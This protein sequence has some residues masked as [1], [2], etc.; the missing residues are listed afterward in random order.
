MV[1][2][3]CGNQGSWNS[4]RSAIFTRMFVKSAN[5][6]L[7]NLPSSPVISLYDFI[8]FLHRLKL[9]AANLWMDFW[10][11]PTIYSNHRRF[12]VTPFIL[13][14]VST[15]YSLLIASSPMQR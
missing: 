13:Q 8:Q 3:V 10:D 9:L 1:V 5:I 14:R 2:V 7:D 15:M 6:H 11:A 4:I 12:V